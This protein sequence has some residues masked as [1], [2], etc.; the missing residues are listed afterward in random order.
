M[1]SF[2]TSTMQN[3]CVFRCNGAKRGWMDW[4]KC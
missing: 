3:S 4:R 1:R 2:V